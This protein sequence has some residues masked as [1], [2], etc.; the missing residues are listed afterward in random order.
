MI[1]VILPAR[2]V[3]DRSTVVKPTGGNPYT[4]TKQGVYVYNP[5]DAKPHKLV[6]DGQYVLHSKGVLNIIQPDD[7]VAVCVPDLDG[8]TYLVQ[9]LRIVEEEG[10]RKE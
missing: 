4:L 3:P 1:R 9:T 6:L 10:D 5:Q 7:L 8:L 2:L